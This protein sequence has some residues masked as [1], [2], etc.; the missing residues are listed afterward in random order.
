M[1]GKEQISNQCRT[2][3]SGWPNELCKSGSFTSLQWVHVTGHAGVT[4]NESAD[5]LAKI[6]SAIL[7][8][9]GAISNDREILNSDNSSV[10]K[11]KVDDNHV[12]VIEKMN[13]NSTSS[14]SR[15]PS[16]KESSEKTDVNECPI[17]EKS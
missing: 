11:D 7:E 8:D 6:G 10:K 1:D 16:G 12:T 5:K 13:M 9:S 14:P 4:G 17:C 15:V 2:K 3:I